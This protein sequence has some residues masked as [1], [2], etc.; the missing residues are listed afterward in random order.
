MTVGELLGRIGAS[1][2]V[3]WAVFLKE[4]AE[5]LKSPA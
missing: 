5:A 4:E 3:D 1:E 2:I